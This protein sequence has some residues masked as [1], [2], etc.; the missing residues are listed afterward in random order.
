[1][2]DVHGP[3]KVM[4]KAVDAFV[5]LYGVDLS[6]TV[7]PTGGFAT[8]N[9]FFTRQLRQ[10]A[11]PVEQGEDVLVCPSDGIIADVGP[12]TAGAA[13]E[14]KGRLYPVAELLDDEEMAARYIGGSFTVIYLAPPDYH[15]VHAA[16][17]GD[18]RQV[19]HVAGT[20][21]PV[22]AIG[23][24][25]PRLLVRNERVVVVQRTP[26]MEVA[27]VLVGAI[28]VGR[29]GLAFDDLRTHRPW[30]EPFRAYPAGAKPIKRGEELGA[31]YLGSTGVLLSTKPWEPIRHQGDRARMGA[32]LGRYVSGAAS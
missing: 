24:H 32:G 21:Y 22:N 27:T 3:D 10:G 14:V 20:L 25:V 23:E 18:I 5:R 19:R 28:G 7:T 31:F 4:R 15:R 2:A 17:D 12:I 30:D 9:D 26:T 13:F 1:M 16:V 11:R 8:F 6:E 29:I